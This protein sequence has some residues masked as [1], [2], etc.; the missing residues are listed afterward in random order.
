MAHKHGQAYAQDLR[1]RVFASADT[2]LGVCRIAETLFVSI[3]YVSKALARRRTTGETAARPQTCHVPPKL[4]DH[5]QTLKE[6]LA[7]K[8]DTTLAELKTWM[9]H[10][11]H[12]DASPSLLSRTLRHMGL[13][14][15]KSPST[16]RSKRETMLSRPVMPGKRARGH[17]IP[18]RSSS[19]MKPG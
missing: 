18:R 2:G 9:A 1:D 14:L 12:I 16:R 5:G 7:D 13:T 3:S 6:R 15:K 8:P 10:N 17:S 11:H 19:L 4:L